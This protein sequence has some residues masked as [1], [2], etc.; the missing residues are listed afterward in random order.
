M[1]AVAP[2]PAWP[3]DP[4]HREAIGTLLTMAVAEDRWGETRR[5]LELLDN[6]EQIVGTLPQPYQRIQMRCRDGASLPV[7]VR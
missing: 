6:A 2:P 1:S 5:A 4:D 7:L 3:A